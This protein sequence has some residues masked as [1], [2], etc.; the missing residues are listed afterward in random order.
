MSTSLWSSER[1]QVEA[2]SSPRG[3]D[4]T[5]LSHSGGDSTAGPFG[6]PHE[7]GEVGSLGPYRLIR[8]LG[9]GG[10]G[11]V[12]EAV[13]TR[14]DRR[15][16][17]KVMLP[18]FAADA[19]AKERFLRE[20]RAAAR[21][22]HDNVV[23]VYEADEHSGTPYIAMEFLEGSSLDSNIRVHG[24]PS[25]PEVLRLATEVSAGLAAAHKL[26]LVHRDIKPGN[27][28]LEAPEGRVKV[29]DFGLA[30]PLDAEVELTQSGMVLGTP[31]YMSPEQARGE[32]VNDRADLF[33]LGA[34]LYRLCTGKLPFQ[35]SNT[36]AV[37]M[38][39]A[40]EEPQPVRDH[41]P[42]VPESLAELIRQLLAKNPEDRPPSAD[43]VR[44]RLL[45]I[46]RKLDLSCGGSSASATSQGQGA[47]LQVDSRPVPITAVTK[48]GLTAV[49]DPTQAPPT[50]S[51][52]TVRQNAGRRRS[53]A[54]VGWA[55]LATVALAGVVVV[56]KNKDGS[57]T[58]IAVPDE[59]TVSVQGT[60]GRTLAQ[61]GPGAAARP[62]DPHRTAAEY[63]LSLGGSVRVNNKNQDILS[64]SSLPEKRFTLTS[65]N[66]NGRPVTDAGLKPFHALA[67]LTE[68]RLVDTRVT[69]P[70]LAE[71]HAA[72][73][74]CRI[75]HDGG[76][77]E[78]AVSIDLDR[79]A[80]VWVLSRDGRVE[81]NGESRDY[82][83]GDTLPSDPFVLTQ[84]KLH[85]KECTDDDMSRL[86]GLSSLEILDLNNTGVTDSGLLRLV[87]LKGLKK[88]TVVN[89]NVTAQ[90]V[91]EFHAAIP[92]CEI[93]HN[94]GL[95][96]PVR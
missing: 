56:I 15:L 57:E 49:A 6:P 68:C 51:G 55:G 22:K 28:W 11:A 13:D 27:L 85:R 31:S 18:Q 67:A 92:G 94:G 40:V 62:V 81:L 47:P 3:Q 42:G 83:R 19:A 35:G 33:S 5:I 26:G 21:I 2:P 72:A 43:H 17:L 9:R 53:L 23:T 36:M 12:Y 95:I 29:L 69:A 37:L 96:E 63:V 4:E 70:A 48:S 60:D 71:L 74:R 50:L 30:K 52:Q 87:G 24:C 88:L 79:S 89:T 45:A 73:P 1:Q 58:R 32:K 20:A 66:L 64:A 7:P 41:N 61:V 86:Q 34:V 76:V 38:A 90:G 78:P 14:L 65:I 39:L 8:E 59:A 54:R 84:V 16:A 77:I 80:A 75:E 91:E 10:M 82:R 93:E 25:L 46:A 44:H